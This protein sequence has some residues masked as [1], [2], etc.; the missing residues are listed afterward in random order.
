MSIQTSICVPDEI[1]SKNQKVKVTFVYFLLDILKKKTC[2]NLAIMY[3]LKGYLH[4]TVW[5]YNDFSITQILREINFED[6]RIVKSAT[7]TH[8]EALTR[9]L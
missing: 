3:N 5:K 6:S 9:F 8:L 7:S 4:F 1:F 2:K